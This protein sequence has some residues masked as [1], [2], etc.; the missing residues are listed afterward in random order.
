[1][2]DDRP[3]SATMTMDENSKKRTLKNA[4]TLLHPRLCIPLFLTIYLTIFFVIASLFPLPSSIVHAV[5]AAEVPPLKGY[6]N[7]YA[8][9]ISPAV[10]TKLTNELKE[11][12]RTDSTQIVILTI[13]SLEGQVIEEY[14]IKVAESWK[15]GQKGRDNGIIFIVANQERKIRIEVGRGLEGKLTDLTAGRIIDLV[16]KPRFKRGDFSGGF[17]AGVAALIDATKGEFKADD[18]KPS[19]TKKSFS[20]FFT[21][22]LFGGVA[23]L[24]LGSISRPLGGVAGALGLPAIAYF[25]L[26]SSIVTIILLGILGLVMGIFLPFLFSGSGHGRGGISPPG[27]GYFGSGGGGSSGDFDSGGGFDGGGGDFGGGGASGDW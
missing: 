7:D 24:I 2:M 1:M 6:V 18:L 26:G 4:K 22:L 20:P 12:E 3:A 23:L 13:P 25:A 21:I 14:S 9:M 27:G 5:H 17:V 15:I 16:V 11:F 8:N 19:K 10:R